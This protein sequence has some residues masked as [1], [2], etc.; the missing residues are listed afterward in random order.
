MWEVHVVNSQ[1]SPSSPISLSPLFRS[2]L[3]THTGR[4]IHTC[5]SDTLSLLSFSSAPQSA[6][7]LSLLSSH[8]GQRD[9][10]SMTL[11]IE[12]HMCRAFAAA[13]WIIAKTCHWLRKDRHN[14]SG[15]KKDTVKRRRKLSVTLLGVFFF[16]DNFCDG[17]SASR[18]SLNQEQKKV[19]N[20]G[21]LKHVEMLLGKAVTFKIRANTAN[22]WESSWGLI[23]FLFFYVMFFC[24]SICL[25]ACKRSA[26]NVCFTTMTS[27]HSSRA[28]S[29]SCLPSALIQF[30]CIQNESPACLFS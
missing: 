30:L 4:R 13:L 15:E 14:Q 12:A 11:L 21:S 5:S 8:K 26:V 7:L 2:P 24:A 25:N 20:R 1:S 17:R 16:L 29:V 6:S 27:H 28:G 3:H 9:Q 22:L 10:Q 19:A 23:F 18:R